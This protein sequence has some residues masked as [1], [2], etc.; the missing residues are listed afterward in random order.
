M[1]KGAHFTNRSLATG[2]EE[3][4]STIRVVTLQIYG[5]LNSSTIME[6]NES[7][8]RLSALNSVLNGQSSLDFLKLDRTKEFDLVWLEQRLEP[9]GMEIANFENL[10]HALG[11]MLLLSLAVVI[12]TRLD[13][14]EAG[15]QNRRSTLTTGSDRNTIVGRVTQGAVNVETAN[16]LRE[17]Y[18]KNDDEEII[19][20]T[21]DSIQPRRLTNGK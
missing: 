7:F 15:K 13:L 1:V 8:K 16:D 14:R 3:A 4:I 11:F 10:Q 18:E 5:A 12:Q 9:L 20:E 17:V 19:T 6:F 21:Q 2:N